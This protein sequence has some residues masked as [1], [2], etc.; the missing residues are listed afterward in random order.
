VRDAVAAL[1][2][3]IDHA[4]AAGDVFNGGPTKESINE[5]ARQMIRRTGSNAD[6]PRALRGGVCEA[7]LEDM[8]RRLPDTSKIVTLIG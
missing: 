8:E 5:L 4:E 3:L 6:R 7:S 1:V 2:A